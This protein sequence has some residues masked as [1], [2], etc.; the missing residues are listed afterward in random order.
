MFKQ[1]KKLIVV[2]L[3]VFM[4]MSSINIYSLADVKTGPDINFRDIEV[5]IDGK[6]LVFK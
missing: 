2:F 3:T 5:F 4:L 6:K 1:K